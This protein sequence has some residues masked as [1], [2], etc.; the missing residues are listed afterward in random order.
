MKAIFLDRDGTLNKEIG[1]V[2]KIEAF[3]LYDDIVLGLQRLG[4][5]ALFIVSNQSGVGRGMFTEAQMAAFNRHLLT[6]LKKEGISILKVYACIHHPDD[7]CKCR[8]PH[9]YFVEEAARE[10]GVTIKDSWV[11]GDRDTD[12]LLGKNAGMHSVLLLTGDGMKHLKSGRMAEPDYIAA[13]FSQAVDFILFDRHDKLISRDE[14]ETV[15]LKER[16]NK[17]TIVTLNGTF[18]ILHQGHRKIIAEAKQQGSCLLVAVNSN[19]SVRGN[20]GSLRPLNSEIARSHMIAAFPEV[21]YVTIFPEAT[22][23]ALL[24]EIKPDVHVNGS[25]YGKDC[26]EASTVRKHG[27][28]IHVVELLP[29]YSTTSLVTVPSVPAK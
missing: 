29:G 23:I 18:D 13:T 27:G 25:E 17:K 8:K 22:P 19:A 6:E 21:D 16:I 5:Y 4:D 11:I 15:I 2:H 7:Q 14:I 26:I 24:E 20:K 28:R 3:E 12:V 1:F 10:V 9:P